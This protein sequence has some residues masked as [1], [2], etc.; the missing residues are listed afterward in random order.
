ML[1]LCPPRHF[2][3]N[4]REGGRA[5]RRWHKPGSPAPATV[6]VPCPC[7]SQPSSASR[8][9]FSSSRC[10]E[11][12]LLKPFF[13]M[14]SSAAGKCL[15]LGPGA[16][17]ARSPWS[18]PPRRVCFAGRCQRLGGC[19]PWLSSQRQRGRRA[20][21]ASP[22]SHWVGFRLATYGTG[23][24]FIIIFL[25]PFPFFFYTPNIIPASF[26]RSSLHG[27]SS[28]R[29]RESTQSL[30]EAALHGPLPHRAHGPSISSC[31]HLSSCGP[32]QVTVTVPTA[33]RS[34]KQKEGVGGWEQL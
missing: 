31:S 24:V 8:L 25:Q 10:T 17:A 16:G 21:P 11:A 27:L 29:P 12:L 4:G 22:R 23:Y 20:R 3:G 9:P 18:S 6:P 32:V 34:H 5:G 19:V 7:S 26:L 2:P 33:S 14:E 15:G 28:L 1:L 30:S 13:V